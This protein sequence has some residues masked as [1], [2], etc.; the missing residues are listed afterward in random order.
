[1]A[2][3]SRSRA[4]LRAVLQAERKAAGQAMDRVI[5][6][7]APT[8]RA[9][10]H[11]RASGPS[12]T[13]ARSLIVSMP[14]SPEPYRDLPG[15]SLEAE[16]LERVL[17]Q[18]TVLTGPT[19]AQVLARLDAYTIV[20]FACHG[21]TEPKEPS[22]SGLILADQ[23]LTVTALNSVTLPVG[24]LAYLSACGTAASEAEGLADRRLR[25]VSSC[26]TIPRHLA[27]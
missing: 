14:S 20:H 7:Y 6:S 4:R 27:R 23:P 25:G 10:A 12:T 15:T 2:S 5:S 21:I 11:A 3:S 24:R 13:A 16:S 17:P 26:G 18:P 22:N 19:A 9:L 8:V 1:M